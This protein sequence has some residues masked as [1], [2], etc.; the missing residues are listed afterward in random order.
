MFVLEV[1]W[2]FIAWYGRSSKSLLSDRND[3]DSDDDDERIASSSRAANGDNEAGNADPVML[4]KL[5]TYIHSREHYP[6]HSSV[7][8]GKSR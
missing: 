3:D 5:A 7:M 2:I 4:L 1:T 8:P 6:I